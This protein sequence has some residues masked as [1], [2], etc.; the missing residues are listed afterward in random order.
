MFNK[1]F[2][3]IVKET[4]C[5][6]QMILVTNSDGTQK[7]AGLGGSPHYQLNSDTIF[8]ERASDPTDG[9]LSPVRLPIAPPPHST[10]QPQ[11]QVGPYTLETGGSKP[12]L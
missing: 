7:R 11:V 2:L 1:I 9:G 10:C 8:P 5:I 4:I 12:H 3:C 6:T